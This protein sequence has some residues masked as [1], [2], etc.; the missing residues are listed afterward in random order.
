M[1]LNYYT[2]QLKN[3]LKLEENSPS[4]KQIFQTYPDL[5][6]NKIDLA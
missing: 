6:P 3:K 5:D 1:A 4:I 2:H